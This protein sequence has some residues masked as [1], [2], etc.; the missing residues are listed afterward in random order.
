[1]NRNSVIW[2]AAHIDV[3]L[4]QDQHLDLVGVLKG[5]VNGSWTVPG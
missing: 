5:D 2:P 4:D 1:M 3:T